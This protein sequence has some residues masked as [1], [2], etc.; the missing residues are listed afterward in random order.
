MFFFIY[1]RSQ[2]Y[3]SRQLAQLHPALTMPMFSE[4]CHRLQTAR[5]S[6]I[7]CLLYYLLPW[8]YNMELVDPNVIGNEETTEKSRENAH[9]ARGGWGTAE[10]TEMVTNNLFYITVKFGDAHP[11]EVE[12]LWAA[13]CACWPKNLRIIIRYLFIVTGLAPNELVDYSKRV[14]LY[15][16][17]AQPVKTLEEMMVELQ[18]VETFNC[19][20]ERT[21]TPPYYRLTSLR[22]A[23]SNSDEKVHLTSSR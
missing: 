11:Q 6:N 13:I 4:I 23:S 7:K 14:L 16:G 19:N 18:T 12:E 1:S 5:P 8:L 22:K 17:R 3:L 9:G 20:I 10:A 21:E 2:L 15:L